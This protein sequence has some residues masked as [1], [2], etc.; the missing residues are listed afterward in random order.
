MA[1]ES[2]SSDAGDSVSQREAVK[3]MYHRKKTL[4]V[5]G[6]VRP[7]FEASTGG[8][9][10]YPPTNKWGLLMQARKSQDPPSESW[11]NRKAGAVILAESKGP[12]TRGTDS[13]SPSP[14]GLRTRSAGV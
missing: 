11:R 2:K 13:V 1:P 4:Y 12:R 6:S 10:V 14:E 7:R 9:G 8:L 5:W 3:C